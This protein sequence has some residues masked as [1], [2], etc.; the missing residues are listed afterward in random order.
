MP[1]N[2]SRQEDHLAGASIPTPV[3]NEERIRFSQEMDSSEKFLRNVFL[4]QKLINEVTTDI[5][6]KAEAVAEFKQKFIE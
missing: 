5:K 4:A 6:T 2:H 1:H 3:D